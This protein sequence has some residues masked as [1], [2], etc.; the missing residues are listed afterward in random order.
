MFLKGCCV[1]GR[2]RRGNVFRMYACV[3]LDVTPNARHAAAPI[4]ISVA[5]DVA[6]FFS[7]VDTYIF[8]ILALLTNNMSYTYDYI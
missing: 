1:E 6:L 2:V 5:I 7:I 4:D 8:F 3:R